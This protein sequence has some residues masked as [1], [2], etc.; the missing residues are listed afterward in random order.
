MPPN[1]QK[2][3]SKIEVQQGRHDEQ[4]KDLETR[5]EERRAADTKLFTK[6]DEIN[7][8]LNK[9]ETSTAIL[10]YKTG[11]WGLVG[12]AIP[13]LITIILIITGKI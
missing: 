3:L 11:A 10:W 5:A 12:G 6:L 7:V 1:E 13:A 4:I 9:L 8:S 2:R